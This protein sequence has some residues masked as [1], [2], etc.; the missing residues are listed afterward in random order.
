M[1]IHVLHHGVVVQSIPLA[2][3]LTVGRAPG[4]DLVIH[5]PSVSGHHAVLYV[6]AGGTWVKDLGSTNGT[7]VR[8]DDAWSR[9]G[10]PIEATHGLR[11]RFG[12]TVEVDVDLV[13]ATALGPLRLACPATGL[14]IGLTS[15]HT[16]VPGVVD[17]M[18][19][20]H[21]DGTASLARGESEPVPLRLEEPFDVD[22]VA[23]VLRRDADPTP[24]TLKP[25]AAGFPYE[26]TVSLEQGRAVLVDPVRE[27]RV[28]LTSDTRVALLYALGRRWLDHGGAAGGAW[29]DDAD[30]G[31][32]I[33]GRAHRSQNANNYNVLIHRL[34]ASLEKAGFE[35]WC[36]EKRPG[37][38]RL[39]VADVCLSDR[40]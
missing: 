15:D 30:A 39:R 21:G 11:L 20:L 32:A 3:R 5:D 38:A 22:G 16:S 24:A 1:P 9:V 14:S 31:L 18:V 37:Q 8:C 7:F 35:R 40:P 10:R 23:F 19:V 4:N 34:R 27:A 6:E 26:L 29:L 13:E 33:W 25:E 28:E 17:A 2:S 12:H 36:V